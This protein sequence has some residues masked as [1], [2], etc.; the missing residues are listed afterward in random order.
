[1]IGQGFAVLL[2]VG[3]SLGGLYGGTMMA[4]DA[5]DGGKAGHERHAAGGILRTELTATPLV[6][7]TSIHGYIVG[8]YVV[9]YDAGLQAERKLPLEML[10]GHAVNRFFYGNASRTFWL[11]GPLDVNAIADG[12]KASI[13]ETA[14]APIVTALAIRQLDHLLSSEIRQPVISFDR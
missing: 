8:R 7:G 4:L 2:A 5:A 9:S 13:N 11:D 10:I 6:T 12:L 14:G 3:A 1:M